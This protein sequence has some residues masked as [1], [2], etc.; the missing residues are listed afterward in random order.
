M[1]QLITMCSCWDIVLQN[2]TYLLTYLCTFIL[3]YLCTHLHTYV[4]TYSLAYINMADSVCLLDRYG[5]VQMLACDMVWLYT[6]V[7]SVLSTDKNNSYLMHRDQADAN[8]VN[9]LGICNNNCMYTVVC[10]GLWHE[11]RLTLAWW[12]HCDWRESTSRLRP[13]QQDRLWLLLCMFVM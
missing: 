7:I 5:N 4:L 3:T 9:G 8:A 11:D 12:K 2:P 13:C 6:L 1:L 10:I